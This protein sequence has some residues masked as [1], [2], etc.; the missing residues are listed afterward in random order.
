MLHILITDDDDFEVDVKQLDEKKHTVVDEEA[1]DKLD[2]NQ[3]CV[4]IFYKILFCKEVMRF[5]L[6]NFSRN[7]AISSFLNSVKSFQA[8]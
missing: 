8:G 4:Y 5:S 6:Q 1:G 3:V 2:L 7:D